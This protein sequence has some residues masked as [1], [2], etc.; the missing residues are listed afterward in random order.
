MDLETRFLHLKEEAEKR[1]IINWFTDFLRTQKRE[2][3]F[4]RGNSY[5]S[6]EKIIGI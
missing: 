4:I 5:T 1:I 2:L 3:K 6:G